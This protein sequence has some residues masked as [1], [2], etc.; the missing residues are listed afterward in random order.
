[1][2][3][4]RHAE[5]PSCPR[6]RVGIGSLAVEEQVVS[7]F[8]GV[9]GYLDGVAVADV[10]RF[11]KSMLEELHSKHPEILEAIRTEGS[12]SGETEEKLG[13][14]LSGFVNVFV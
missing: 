12:L 11:E 8:S 9:R 10:T 13:G 6:Q 4:H 3:D 2:V 14:F 1:M 7:I 5:L